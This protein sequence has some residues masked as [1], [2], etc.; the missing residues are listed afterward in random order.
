MAFAWGEV[1]VFGVDI[2]MDALRW[3]HAIV[4]GILRAEVWGSLLKWSVG[5]EEDCDP[6]G[7]LGLMLPYILED[8]SFPSPLQ[9][10]L[11]SFRRIHL[12]VPAA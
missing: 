2:V 4:D 1:V 12:L 5:C 10:A 3:V 6:D 7:S 8:V 11:A 9:T